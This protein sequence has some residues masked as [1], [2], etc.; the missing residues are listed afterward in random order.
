MK[1]SEQLKMAISSILVHK[2]RSVLTIIGIV[3]GVASVIIVVAIGNGGE[4]LLKGVIAGPGNTI[5]VFYNLEEEEFDEQQANDG[6]FTQQDVNALKEISGVQNIVASSSMFSTSTFMDES[7]QLSV[8]GVTDTYFKVNKLGLHK[9]VEF[10]TQDFL[11]GRNTGII[12]Y[13]LFE[14]MQE[15]NMTNPLGEVLWI[16]GQPIKIT[17]VAEKP[18]GLFSFNSLEVYL[19]SSTVNAVFGQ[20]NFNQL[21]LQVEDINDMNDVGKRA[22]EM[23]NSMHNTGDSYEVINI[24]EMAEGIGKVTNIMT[25]IIGSIAGI[26]LF[27]GGVGVMNIMLVSVTERTREIGIRKAL[28]ATN[29]Q[30]LSQFL[31]EAIVLTLTG[32]IIGV[33]FGV[34]TSFAVSKI[35]GWPSLISWEIITIGV[36]FSALIGTIFGLLPAKKAAKLDPID[37]LRYE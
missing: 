37:S 11:G 19:P 8:L 17:G 29:K 13:A 25:I 35:A 15:K 6:D 36:L 27:V 23:L 3:I 5:E 26:S 9:G 18:E 33:M 32:G 4:A 31:I 20:K 12:S 16:K 7:Y 14:K 30:I 10:S 2:M 22:T 21:T 34:V 24:E 28:G 1:V